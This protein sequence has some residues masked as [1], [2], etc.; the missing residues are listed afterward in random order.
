MMRIKNCFSLP[1]LSLLTLTLSVPLGAQETAEDAW[2]KLAGRF[3]K[4]PE[5]AYVKNDPALPN[6]LIYGDS[7]SIGYT[8]PLRAKMEGKANIY[9]LYHNGG[10]STKLISMMEKMHKAMRDEQLEDPWTFEWDV[11]HF[12]VGLHDLTVTEEDKENGTHESRTSIDDY[13]KNLGDIVTYLKK[14]APNAKLIFATTTPVPEGTFKPRRIAGDSEKYNAAA[15]EVLSNTPEIA[16]N[17][18]FSFTKKKHSEWWA[19]P[20]DVHYNE[21]G[22]NA[23]GDEVARFILSTLAGDQ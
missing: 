18:L 7:I 15:L 11:I 12:N 10:N 2:A 14:L 23:Q 13:K 3:A 19:A 22:R 8:Q 16:V 9:R 17:D 4:R 6:V 5:F 1:L 20:G 21:A